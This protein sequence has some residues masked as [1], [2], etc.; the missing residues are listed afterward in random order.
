MKQRRCGSF[1]SSLPIGGKYIMDVS[2]LFLLSLGL[3]A[4]VI[5]AVASRLLYVKEDPRIELVESS[6]A[7]AN[8]G[9]CGYPAVPGQPEPWWQARRAWTSA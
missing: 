2:V 6:L 8:C 9:G 4:A 7:G 5:L 3:I 1:I